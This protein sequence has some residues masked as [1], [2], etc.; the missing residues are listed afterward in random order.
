MERRLGGLC[1][2]GDGLVNERG[3]LPQR[4]LTIALSVGA[5]SI[6]GRRE[7]ADGAL[8]RRLAVAVASYMGEADPTR[9]GWRFPEFRRGVEVEDRR[10][11]EL[12]VDGDLWERFSAEADRQGVSAEDLL[13]HALLYFAAQQDSGALAERLGLDL[14]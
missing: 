11:C 2:Y 6:A 7:G 9:P 14:S 13:E 3:N 10:P 1:R 5:L 12:R 4:D 8:S